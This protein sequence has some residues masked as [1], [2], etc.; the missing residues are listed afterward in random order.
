MGP[1]DSEVM[2]SLSQKIPDREYALAE[3]SR[4]FV[5]NRNNT[6]ILIPPGVLRCNN[7]SSTTLQSLMCIRITWGII[8]MK[9]SGFLEGFFVMKGQFHRDSH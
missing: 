1:L 9:T 7:A 2:I 6:S 8:K 4:L 3:L 5:C